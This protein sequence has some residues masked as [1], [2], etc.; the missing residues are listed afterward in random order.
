[1]EHLRAVYV[2]SVCVCFR[3]ET[4]CVHTA[5]DRNA[6]LKSQ[7]TSPRLINIFRMPI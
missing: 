4:A 7:K 6:N 2:L 5:R 3:F 1:M